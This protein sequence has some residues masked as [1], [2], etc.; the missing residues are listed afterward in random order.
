MR[1]IFS[2]TVF[3]FVALAGG[4]STT[5]S[6]ETSVRSVSY[7]EAMAFEQSLRK[8]GAPEPAIPEAI[9]I[10]PVNKVEP[11]KLPTSQDQLERNNFRAYWDGQ[12]RDGYA[13][14]L[15]RDIAVSDTHHVEEVTTHNGKIDNFDRPAVT[16][17]FVNNS[18][19]Y[20]VGDRNGAHS[21]FGERIESGFNGFSVG[22]WT[23]T[24]DKSGK[25]LIVGSPLN[26]TRILL[27]TH[28]S[29]TY[30]FTDNTSSP[31]VD[32]TL[33]VFVAEIQ[34]PEAEKVGGFVIIRYGNGH[35][36][37]FET[38]EGVLEPVTLP[39]EYI[40]YVN[41]K[42]GEVLQAYKEA[43]LNLERA[44]QIE[45]EY[46]Y[47]ACNGSYE[48]DNLEKELSSK[49]CSWRSQFEEPLSV[50]LAQYAEK[51]EQMKQTA[52]TVEQQ[53]RYQEQIA[54]QQQIIR[55]QQ[56]QQV[57]QDGVNA[58]S[59]IG[60]KMHNSGLQMQQYF[61]NQISP[62]VAPLSLPGNDQ[63]NCV[64]VGPVVNCRH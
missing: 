20:G 46:L 49:I 31:V 38:N 28:G 6:Q 45:R 18:V 62:Q 14:G 39:D 37:H 43:D 42:Y 60:Q 64:S 36:G 21:V 35:V 41:K 23:G 3:I 1:C 8:E 34:G 29:V 17:D 25:E 5:G 57:I 58:L 16:Y 4:C 63:I 27:K 53:R 11:C 2:C 33:P 48:I 19:V 15:G 54:F 50:A 59:Q 51:L 22:Y 56:S 55:Q 61:M 47:L 13:Y 30:K 9:F 44:R 32:P 52:K 24:I 40:A 26:S 10:Q 12:C 7:A